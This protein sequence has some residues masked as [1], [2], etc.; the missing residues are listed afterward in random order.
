MEKT[1]RVYLK[2][3]LNT[4]IMLHVTEIGKQL[5]QTLENKLISKISNK[6]ISEGYVSPNGIKI[7]TYS[8]GTVWLDSIVF[9]VVYECMISHPIEGMQISATAQT[10]T[11]AG[12]HA[13]VTDRDGNIP[14]TVFV[15]RDHSLSDKL[16]QVV[17]KNDSIIVKVIGIR[18]ELNDP[19]ICVIASI[20][21][22]NEKR[23]FVK[24][25]ETNHDEIDDVD[26]EYD[27][28]NNDIDN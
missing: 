26:D 19:N 24:G 14:I 13:S 27:I 16:F 15:A 25:G 5:K 7:I 28:M 8:S 21:K 17:K 23:Q 10:V 18:Y 11:K 1:S 9:E 2:S 3:L 22:I 6:C 4:K 20:V 12:I